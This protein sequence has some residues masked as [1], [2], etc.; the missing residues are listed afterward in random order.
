MMLVVWERHAS[1]DASSTHFRGTVERDSHVASNLVAGKRFAI[2]GTGG[3]LA[4]FA[5][6]LDSEF[7]PGHR[8]HDIVAGVGGQAVFVDR[9]ALR[10]EMPANRVNDVRFS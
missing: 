2:P 3:L 4:A 9:P 8:R 7:L 1:L 5:L 10:F 6:G